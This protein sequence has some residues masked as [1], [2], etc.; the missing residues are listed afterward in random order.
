MTTPSDQDLRRM[1]AEA[2]NC[3]SASKLIVAAINALPRLLDRVERA[4]SERRAM[5]MVDTGNVDTDKMI[6][7]HRALLVMAKRASD[8][9]GLD[10]SSSPAEVLDEI[11][12]LKGE[13]EK[14]RV[15]AERLIVSADKANAQAARNVDE[16]DAARADADRLAVLLERLR[17]NHPDMEHRGLGGLRAGVRQMLSGEQT[18]GLWAE[19][20]AALAGRGGRKETT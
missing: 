2:T 13:V 10:D 4:E 17:K 19:V 5:A 14:E 11:A 8:L 7:Q 12:R 16:R 3:D 9:V 20:D 15:R 6:A 1:L 18:C